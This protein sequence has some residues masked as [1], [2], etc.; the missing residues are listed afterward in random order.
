MTSLLVLFQVSKVVSLNQV[1]AIYSQPYFHMCISVL[2]P[3]RYLGIAVFAGK[4]V[5]ARLR[6]FNVITSFSVGFTVAPSHACESLM[7]VIVL[8]T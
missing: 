4:A 5:F 3:V 7:A 1:K 8:L 2:K 6:R